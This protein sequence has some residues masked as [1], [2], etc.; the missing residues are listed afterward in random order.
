MHRR[1]RPLVGVLVDSTMDIPST[2]A[3]PPIVVERLGTVTNGMLVDATTF[4][5]RSSTDTKVVKHRCG[6]PNESSVA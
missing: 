1:I 3:L 5:Y 4:W 2:N 6:H